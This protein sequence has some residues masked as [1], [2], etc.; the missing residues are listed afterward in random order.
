MSIVDDVKAARKFASHKARSVNVI[1]GTTG[2]VATLPTNLTPPLTVTRESGSTSITMGSSGG[3]LTAS[4]ASSLAIGSSLAAIAR[5]VQGD[6]AGVIIP[7]TLTGVAVP[8]YA[9]AAPTVTLTAGNGQ[10]SIAWTDGSNGGAAITS[11]RIYVN[12][13]PMSPYAGSSPYVL[14]GLANGTAVSIAVAAINSVAGEGPAS[15]AQSVTPSAVTTTTLTR[16]ANGTITVSSLGPTWS[17]QLT[18]E[19]NGNVTV[20]A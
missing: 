4:I 16:E 2:V 8:I 17:P 5:V 15:S 6:G 3:S 9:P 11:H 10:I 12:G 20:G 7:I 19:A 1:T 18:R 14:T 13:T